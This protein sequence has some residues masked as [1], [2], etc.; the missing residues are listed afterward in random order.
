MESS[1]RLDCAQDLQR[2]RL[3]LARHRPKL[4]V[5]DPYVRLQRA[6]E[7]CDASHNSSYVTRPV[8]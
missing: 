8:M 5:L 3:T 4:L 7:L 6:D 1:L 2:L